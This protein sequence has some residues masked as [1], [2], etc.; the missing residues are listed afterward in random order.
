MVEANAV[1]VIWEH[2]QSFLSPT[3]KESHWRETLGLGGEKATMSPD[4][5][6]TYNSHSINHLG[7]H[8]CSIHRHKNTQY[9]KLLNRCVSPHLVHM[10]KECTQY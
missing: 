4:I 5:P 3:W 2:L 8:L 9:G 7:I 6:S 1:D 10:E